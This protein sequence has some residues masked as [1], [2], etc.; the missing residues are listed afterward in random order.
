MRLWSLH[1]EYLDQKGILAVWR[2]GLLAQ[3]VLAGKTKGYKKHPQLVRF[4]N[5]QDPLSA[6]NSYLYYIWLES[7]KRGY[8]FDQSKITGVGLEKIINITQGQINY[9]LSHLLKKV[10]MRDSERFLKLKKINLA[11][12]KPHPVFKIIKGEV[13]FWEKNI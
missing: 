9:E 12:I 3:K 13:E 11:R 7:R 4:Q 10:Q 6:I 5:H 2:E 1:P 8:F